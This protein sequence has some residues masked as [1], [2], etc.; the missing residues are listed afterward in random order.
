MDLK[1]LQARSGR[2]AG[3]WLAWL[4]KYS[5]QGISEA[6]FVDLNMFPSL[7]NWGIFRAT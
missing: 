7:A 5:F 2:G 3:N 1:V 4:K 6:G